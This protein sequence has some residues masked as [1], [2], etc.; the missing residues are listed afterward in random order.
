[1]DLE[2][3]LSYYQYDESQALQFNFIPNRLVNK[4]YCE[5]LS[6]KLISNCNGKWE[7]TVATPGLGDSL[8]DKPG[9]YMF[10]WRLFFPFVFDEYTSNINLILYIGKAGTTDGNGSL[11]SRYKNEYSK[12]V[13]TNAEKIWE[14]CQL[15]SRKDRL[16][17]FLNLYELE[18]W[19]AVMDNCANLNDICDIEDRLIKLF[20]PPANKSGLR[21]KYS[22]PTDAF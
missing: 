2:E 18:Y 12:F 15:K 22:Q 21:M 19:F 3:A 9:I 10:V 7:K 16:S 4:K 14:N 11:K 1:M 6:E 13:K 5:K 20:N 17:K 8:P